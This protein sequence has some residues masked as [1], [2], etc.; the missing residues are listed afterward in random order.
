M[1]IPIALIIFN[2]AKQTKQVIDALRL[3]KP[4]KLY[5][6]ADGPRNKDEQVKC[7]DA[8]SVIET[9]DWKCE[10][11]KKYSDK[12]LGCGINESLGLDWV[13]AQE[14][15][16]IILED[17]CLPHPSFFPFC[18]ELLDRYK[19][20]EKV[21]HISGNFFQHKNRKFNDQNSYYGSI[22]P[23]VWGWATWSRAWKKY[24]YDLNQWPI[25]KQNRTLVSWFNNPASYEYWSGIWDEYHRKK[26]NNYDARW[27]FACMVNKGICINPTSNLVTNI[28]FDENATHTKTP[29]ESANIP[30][31]AMEFPLEHPK[32]L[33]INH[34]ADAFTLRKNFGVDEKIRHRILRPIKDRFP[35][36][37]WKNR[38]KIKHAKQRINTFK[39]W[40]LFVWPITRIGN[41]SRIAV[42][43]D[44]SRILMRSIF[45]ADLSVTMELSPKNPYS[46]EITQ[47]PSTIADI[48][49]NIGVY[50]V[51]IARKYPNAK[52]YAI[53]PEESNFNQLLKNI[54]L[55][56]LKNVIP[57]RAVVSST[58][59]KR[60]LNLSTL[61]NCHSLSERNGNQSQEVETITLKS[62]GKIDLLKIDVEG[63]EYE[64]FRDYIPEC[65]NIVMEIHPDEKES[66]E[67]LINKFRNM[68]SVKDEYPIY[69]MKKL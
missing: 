19:N 12:N 30:T 41:K 16:A 1:K 61:S 7:T 69:K 33:L 45:S 31:K 2:R 22:L 68:Y 37:Y 59:G 11:K 17:D 50:M 27:G 18:S 38:N 52:V 40:P 6:V 39:N 21:M 10:I 46:I 13:F 8:R 63:A 36:L 32:N 65:E 54:K 51:Y 55:N 9:I 28:G 57:I 64:I 25:I 35:N 24:D 20:D 44:G 49:A 42:L 14:D 4:E 29:D 15:Q 53:E 26:V 43:K 5:V 60:I 3:V 47:D 58:S 67:N 48:G 56:N 66:E 34:Q 23:H 62:L